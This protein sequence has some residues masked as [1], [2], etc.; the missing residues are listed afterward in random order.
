LN[1]LKPLILRE[2]QEDFL[3]ARGA[4][5]LVV[6][7]LV[8]SAFAVLLVSNTELS[9]LDNAEAV[10]MMSGIIVALGALIAVIRGSEGFAG[11]RER[12]TLEPLLLAPITGHQIAS[13]KL[14]GILF[15]W[16][17]LYILAVPYLWAVGSTGQN[18]LPALRYLFITGTLTVVI[19]GGLALIL[20]VKMRTFRGGL[21]VSLTILLLLGSPV[22]LGSSLRQSMVGRMLD[23]INPLAGALNTLDSV[24]ID[25]QGLAFQ[26]LRI[27]IMIGY[28]LV[29]IWALQL[30]TRRIEP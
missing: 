14:L 26:L 7:T 17:T 27:S 25:S 21:S 10:Y 23:M 20:S 19:F 2:T 22:V 28:T 18:L 13:A 4:F 5:F 9:L 16:G 12:E 11:E 3:S 30:A 15:S 1:A 6:A 29:V 24:I 8:L